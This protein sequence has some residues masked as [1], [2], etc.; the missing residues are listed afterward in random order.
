MIMTMDCQF[1]DLEVGETFL[2]LGIEF[3]KISQIGAAIIDADEHHAIHRFHLDEVV[4]LAN[5][6]LV[7]DDQISKP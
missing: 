7:A 6:A 1:R 2:H 5:H 3:R 4:T